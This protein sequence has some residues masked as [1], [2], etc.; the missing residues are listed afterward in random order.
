MVAGGFIH[1]PNLILAGDLNFTT[2]AAKIW[3]KK[4]LLYPLAPFFTH[5]IVE[6]DL[7]DLAPPY[8]GPT[9]RNCRAGD[10]GIS[11]RL[12]RFLISSFV[13]TCLLKHRVWSA[14]LDV[15]DH[16][17]ICLEWNGFASVHNYPFKFNRAWLLEDEFSQ[18]V[19]D[20]WSSMLP[21]TV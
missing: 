16:F 17:P 7:V 11:K 14:P 18:L 19:M 12:E 1:L 5:L 6:H 13:V 15:L 8:A 9:W 10:E 2:I 21:D 3:G 20:S 4:S